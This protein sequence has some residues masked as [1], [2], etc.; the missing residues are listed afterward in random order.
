MRFFK[1]KQVLKISIALMILVLCM[2]SLYAAD[3][4]DNQKDVDE[5]SSDWHIDDLDD[6]YG[7]FV[8]PHDHK[9]GVDD[10]GRIHLI[11]DDGGLDDDSYSD[12]DLDDDDSDWEDDDDW[13]DDLDDDSDWEDDD[14]WDDDLDD[15]DSDWEDDDDWDDDL[16]DDDSDWEDDDDWDDDLDDDDSDWDDDDDWDDD[17]DDDDS[18]WDDDDDWDYDDD[19]DWDDDDDWDYDDDF[20]WEDDDDWLYNDDFDWGEDGLDDDCGNLSIYKIKPIYGGLIS[21]AISICPYPYKYM[22]Y[23]SVK[24]FESFKV[25]ILTYLD[26][27]GNSSDANWTESDEFNEIYQ[28]Y[29]KDNSSYCINQSNENYDTYMKIYDSIVS[30][31]GYGNLT[32]N[33]TEY[34]KV[35]IMYYLNNYG[36]CINDTW[37]ETS[38]Y[39]H[40][41]AKSLYL[42]AVYFD[43][44]TDCAPDAMADHVPG[45]DHGS[46]ANQ[47]MNF[48]LNDFALLA[49]SDNAVA[50]NSTS[51]DNMTFIEPQTPHSWFDDIVMMFVVALFMLAMII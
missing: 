9:W 39:G 14:D 48:N 36:N 37:N 34:L 17:L 20:D 29:L 33:E 26:R 32:D 2:G 35:L 6:Y 30:T 46:A 19:F 43:L 10:N 44:A 24:H 41:F 25:D 49:S 21:P 8:S 5:F 4:V 40:W 28:L 11:E 27:F 18:D 3:S 1:P 23:S 45:S 7:H 22:A 42:G 38:G 47:Y 31:F 50:S 16:D 13:D 12:D 51:T 15:D